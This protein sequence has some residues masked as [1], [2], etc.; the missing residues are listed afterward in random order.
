[1]KYK[2]ILLGFLIVMISV[3]NAQL[4]EEGIR[5]DNLVKI[6]NYTYQIVNQEKVYVSF[7]GKLIESQ[8]IFLKN[9]DKLNEIISRINDLEKEIEYKQAAIDQLNKAILEKDQEKEDL[10][11][12]I[13]TTKQQIE[14]LKS[15]IAELNTTLTQLQ[16][17]KMELV[18]K[19]TGNFLLTKTQTYALATLF[20]VLI[21]SAII[22]EITSKK[23]EKKK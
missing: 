18:N 5:E 11:K 17:E 10:E 3:A 1:M 15:E 20:I 19:I 23:K 8:R 6:G 9:L 4:L 7:N 2:T 14:T 13:N 16:K 21:I 22:L 12:N